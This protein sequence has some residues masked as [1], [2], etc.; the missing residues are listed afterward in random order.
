[1]TKSR[2][3]LLRLL[4]LGLLLGLGGLLLLGTRSDTPPALHIGETERPSLVKENDTRSHGNIATCVRRLEPLSE[5]FTVQL[6]S[7]SSPFTSTSLVAN[8]K[9]A[10]LYLPK[11]RQTGHL[12]CG[13]MLI[14]LKGNYALPREDFQGIDGFPPDAVQIDAAGS[15][16]TTTG[17][18]G[19]ET[20]LSFEP[21]QGQRI[22]VYPVSLDLRDAGE[23]S[24]S[25]TLECNV[26][27]VSRA[28]SE[29]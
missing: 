22:R 27:S 18:M 24:V 11:E 2:T 3:L 29:I 6:L 17:R 21:E 4:G 25:G 28:L 14:A 5:S 8:V 19:R 13:Y 1:M 20:L 16:A 26:F 10:Y 12:V 15:H 23:Y 9:A 7:S